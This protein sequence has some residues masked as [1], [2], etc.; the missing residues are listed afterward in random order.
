[1]QHTEKFKYKLSQILSFI[2][3]NNKKVFATMLKAFIVAALIL[4]IITCIS[5][6]NKLG[7]KDSN[8]AN[9]NEK[10]SRQKEQIESLE[11]QLYKTQQ[12][13]S[14]LDEIILEQQEI[15]DFLQTT[16]LSTISLKNYQNNFVIHG[17][18]FLDKANK[19]GV[20]IGKNLDVLQQGQIYQIW[21]VFK[22]NPKSIGTFKSDSDG[23]ALLKLE[24]IPNPN[25]IKRFIIT[26]EI[27]TG[28]EEPTGDVYLLGGL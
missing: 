3:D 4:S 2:E 14:N 11:N 20:L 27:G 9:T 16:T 26:K 1:M 25:K 10:I 28:S 15:L 23:N 8:F 19:K 5:F 24:Y 7:Q 17:K 18:I 21:A 13:I 12:L 6:W 22:I